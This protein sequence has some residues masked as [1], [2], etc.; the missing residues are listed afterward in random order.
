MRGVG[1]DWSCGTFFLIG[2]SELVLILDGSST[3]CYVVSQRRKGGGAFVAANPSPSELFNNTKAFGRSLLER[4]R[5]LC[6]MSFSFLH[7]VG[8][9]GAGRALVSTNDKTTGC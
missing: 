6:S 9:G 1:R 4:Y 7:V 2:F 8:G 5:G 3:K